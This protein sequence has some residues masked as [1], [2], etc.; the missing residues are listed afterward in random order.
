MCLV[1]QRVDYPE[2]RRLDDGAVL[3]RAHSTT[4]GAMTMERVLPKRH[5]AILKLSI[6]LYFLLILV[7][8]SALSANLV[9]MVAVG[10]VALVRKMLY[11]VGRKQLRQRMIDNGFGGT[12]N[13]V[14]QPAGL[15]YGKNSTWPHPHHKYFIFHYDATNGDVVVDGTI[16]KGRQKFWSMVFYDLEGVPQPQY[17]ND[18]S[19]GAERETDEQLDYKV[20]LTTKEMPC[21]SRNTVCVK[22]S[23]RGVCII[24]LLY[25][26]DEHVITTTKPRL[27]VM[28]PSDATHD[29]AAAAA[30]ANI[31]NDEE[32]AVHRMFISHRRGHRA[33][34][35][36]KERSQ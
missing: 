28:P 3:R 22:G 32:V 36:P 30:A 4:V 21:P 24:R 20:V 8:F 31:K 23:P 18:R 16:L 9:L 13:Q 11:A 7:G 29:T 35:A 17:Y 1:A 19:I 33:F 26:E 12:V 5:Y 14:I 2:V 10:V 15:H 25:P 27:T 6:L 34:H